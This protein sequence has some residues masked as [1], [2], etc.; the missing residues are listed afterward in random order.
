MKK[1]QRNYLKLNN[2][3]IFAIA[4]LSLSYICVSAYTFI[5]PEGLKWA[6]TLPVIQF[7]INPD[8]QG[9]NAGTEE[10]RLEVIQAAARNWYQ[11]GQ[12][13]FTMVY[14]EQTDSAAT[15]GADSLS[16]NQLDIKQQHPVQIFASP[17]ADPDCTGKSCTY[18]WN[19]SGKNEIIHADVQLNNY[20]YSISLSGTEEQ[21]IDLKSESLHALGHVIG[22]DHCQPGDTQ[23]RCQARHQGVAADP[24][25]GA[26]MYKFVGLLQGLHDDDIAGVKALY[27]P[28]VLPIP[29]TGPYALSQDDYESVVGQMTVEAQYGLNTEESRARAADYGLNLANFTAT[30]EGQ[31][32]ENLTNE[33]YDTAIASVA[34]SNVQEL[35]I[36]RKLV[37]RG[38]YV[39]HRMIKDAEAGKNNWSV[40]F[41]TLVLNKQI[42][43]RNATIDAQQAGN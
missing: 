21:N 14:E 37:T 7:V 9:L 4:A 10:E 28:L 35:A 15:V 2:R 23:T 34:H 19:C 41:L 20:D 42:A 30:R 5:I 24:G 38:I 26:V 13:Q 43:L 31:S 39:T 1:T 11:S 25:D 8:F 36:G 32:L 3:K 22:L 6:G 18:V 12:A 16:C 27:G 33:F 40:D 17:Q 29:V